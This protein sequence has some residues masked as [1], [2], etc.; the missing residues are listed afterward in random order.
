MV[1]D[2]K[3]SVRTREE[4]TIN[5]YYWT[6]VRKS[7]PL[8]SL[9]VDVVKSFERKAFRGDGFLPSSEP[10][11]SLVFVSVYLEW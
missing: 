3:K 9:V 8:D 1:P 6:A 7:L 5:L 10:Y 2:W 4:L 11:F